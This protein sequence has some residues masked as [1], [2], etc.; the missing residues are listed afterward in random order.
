MLL[1]MALSLYIMM[2]NSFQPIELSQENQIS[3]VNP[4]LPMNDL[5]QINCQ[6]LPI[7]GSHKF[8][9]RGVLASL[10]PCGS[11]DS[12]PCTVY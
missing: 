7:Q 10:G 2:L 6:P 1:V 5:W 11:H 3:M 9:S 8:Y 4:S 12:G